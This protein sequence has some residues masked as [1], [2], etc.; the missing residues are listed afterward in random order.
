[1]IIKQNVVSVPKTITYEEG[2]DS[3]R[4]AIILQPPGFWD[5]Q[6][7][8]TLGAV[9]AERQLGHEELNETLDMAV[10][11]I[12]DESV[13]K[14]K[15]FDT[16]FIDFD[17]SVQSVEGV[18]GTFGTGYPF[19]AK[20]ESGGIYRI[21]EMTRYIR[22]FKEPLD[23]DRKRD[24]GAWICGVCE[25]VKSLPDL[26][27]HCKP[28]DS[29]D[30][31]PRDIFRALPDLDYWV[32][33]EDGADLEKI[34]PTIEANIK[35]DG[36]FTSDEDVTK[37]IKATNQAMRDIL[38]GN[39]PDTKLPIDLHVVTK[40]QLLSC[41]G[42]VNLALAKG[43]TVPITP[44]SLHKKWEKA[45]APYDFLK[46]FLFS[47]TPNNWRESECVQALGD[48]RVAAREI[49]GD[50]AVAIVSNMAEKEARQLN[51]PGIREALKKRVEAW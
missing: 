10:R 45:D 33:V 26:K 36:F 27:T 42:D 7:D 25:V 19:Y 34:L 23:R 17:R 49:V 13:L 51:T 14:E 12:D 16:Q 11:F 35:S 2:N 32:I 47:L 46:D 3:S 31:K 48:A 38:K 22:T 8:D 5:D 15:Y 37:A 41:I 1:M 4:R 9:M 50:D 29:V 39:M 40:S 30:F 18:I 44:I 43:L 24:Y 21:G 20:K 6:Q 28:C